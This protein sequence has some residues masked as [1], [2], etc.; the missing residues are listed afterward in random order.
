VP[1]FAIQD[2]VVGN[3]MAAP[4][5]SPLQAQGL[6]AALQPHGRELGREGD[7]AGQSMR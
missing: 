4:A 2:M 1:L 5:G 7:E 3:V 6:T